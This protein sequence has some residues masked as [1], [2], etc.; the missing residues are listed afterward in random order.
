MLQ[1]QS[2]SKQNRK[3]VIFWR[4]PVNNQKVWDSRDTTSY[5]KSPVLAALQGHHREVWCLTIS[6]NGDH[7]VSSSHDKSLRLWERTR[8]PLILEEEREMVRQKTASNGHADTFKNIV[9]LHLIS[10]FFN[11]QEREAEFEESMAKGDVPVVNTEFS[12]CTTYCIYLNDKALHW[13][14]S[15]KLWLTLRWS[16]GWS[17]S[18]SDYCN[19]NN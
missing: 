5:D 18:S 1:L 7:I 16:D 11:S 12:S 19:S 3:S 2:K 13:P 17:L 10:L 8:E 15:C 9:L 14:M 6:P 4:K